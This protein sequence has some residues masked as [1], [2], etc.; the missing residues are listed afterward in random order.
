MGLFNERR[1]EWEDFYNF[2]RPYGA[3]GGQAT[4]ERLRE[5]TRGS[6]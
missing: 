3:L 6:V 5:T 1:K 2:N 4:Y